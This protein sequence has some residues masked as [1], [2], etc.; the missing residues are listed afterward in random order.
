LASSPRRWSTRRR[1]VVVLFQH[2][3]FGA[4]IARALG[5]ND[6]LRVTTLALNTLSPRALEAMQ[7]DAI[8]VEGPMTEDVETSLLGMAPV[9]TVV[10]GSESNTAE[11]YERHEVIHAS[12]A[13]ITARIM[14]APGPKRV[15][16]AGRRTSEGTEPE[17]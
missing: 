1:Y 17:R 11:V 13:E 8:I 4:A 9:L 5:E 12:A 10:V 2:H 3:L 16:I 7:S 15:A 14:A 6:H